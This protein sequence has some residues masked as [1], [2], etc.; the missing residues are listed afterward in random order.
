M[1]Q[2]L[3]E[4]TLKERNLESRLQRIEKRLNILT[5]L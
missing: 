2:Q 1:N 3:R 5:T 4:I